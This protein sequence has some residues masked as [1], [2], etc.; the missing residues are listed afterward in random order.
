MI[1]YPLWN[2]TMQLCGN[3]NIFIVIVIAKAEK[4]TEN[5]RI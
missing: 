2:T 5:V 3:K 1:I 4:M